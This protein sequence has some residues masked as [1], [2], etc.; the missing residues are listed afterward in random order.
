MSTLTDQ[1]P[2]KQGLK[3]EASDSDESDETLTDQLPLKQGLKHNFATMLP[4]PPKSH[5]PTSIKTRIETIQLI[6]LHNCNRILTDQLPLKQGL[7]PN[8][9]FTYSSTEQPSHRPTSIKT[10]IETFYINYFAIYLQTHRP[11]SIK[12]RI[13]THFLLIVLYLS[14]FSQTNFH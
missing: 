6:L 4:L 10:R 7:K 13:E 1:L 12:T 3:L 5:R 14:F 8:L 2:L 9:Y 11:T